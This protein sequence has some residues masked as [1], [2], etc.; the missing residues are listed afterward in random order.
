MNLSSKHLHQYDRNVEH[1]RTVVCN[2]QTCC[3]ESSHRQRSRSQKMTSR[4]KTCPSKCKR[5][6]TTTNSTCEKKLKYMRRELPCIID[7]STCYSP[8]R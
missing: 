2:N 4:T 6:T 3:E 1:R 8:R 5:C 7:Q